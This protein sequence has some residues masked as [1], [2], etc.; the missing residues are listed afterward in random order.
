MPCGWILLQVG[1]HITRWEAARYAQ[2][3]MRTLCR[4]R[5]RY[6]LT[7]GAG[8]DANVFI[9]LNGDKGAMG[10][11]RI[12]NAQNNFERGR[13]DTFKIKG[14]DVGDVQK[15][16]IRHDDSGIGSDW[17]LAQV[18]EHSVKCL[19]VHRFQRMLLLSFPQAYPDSADVCASS[20]GSP[21]ATSGQVRMTL[22]VCIAWLPGRWR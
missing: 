19:P 11:S 12:D 4:R 2:T 22:T 15:V 9:A 3:R 16:I 21:C 10:E 6:C 20:V 8:T 14:S 7:R 13:V 1:S 18:C 17:H 5:C